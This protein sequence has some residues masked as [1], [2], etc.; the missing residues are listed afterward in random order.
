MN[1]GPGRSQSRSPV[2]QPGLVRVGPRAGRPPGLAPVAS[3]P[4]ASP[5]WTF[6]DAQA[7]AFADALD[8]VQD[9]LPGRP[10]HLPLTNLLGGNPMNVVNLLAR[11]PYLQHVPSQ[12]REAV[13]E[14][15]QVP[16]SEVAL[17]A[18]VALADSITSAPRS[19]GAAQRCHHYRLRDPGICPCRL[20]RGQTP[21]W[22]TRSA[23][24]RWLRVSPSGSTDSCPSPALPRRCTP[25]SMRSHAPCRHPR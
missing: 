25:Y 6:T 15:A 20:V 11:W 16:L 13:R 18:A 2:L 22:S 17:A 14:A 24:G 3:T 10:I 5:T 21:Q 1:V 7:T 4:G 12:A 8:R 9:D 23:A 19:G